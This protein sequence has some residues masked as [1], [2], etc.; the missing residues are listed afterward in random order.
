MTRLVVP[1]T[2]RRD[3]RDI[4]MDLELRARRGVALR[5]ARKFD[6]LLTSIE[7][8]PG[9]CSPRPRLGKKIRCSAV[10]PYLVFFEYE[11]LADT[12]TVLR[13]L[14]GHRRITRKLLRE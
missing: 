8:F 13:V 5:T 1:E 7:Q 9:T 2:A 12:V 3:I 14:H 4:V 10:H 6:E 11:A